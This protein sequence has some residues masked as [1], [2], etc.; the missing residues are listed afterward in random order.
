MSLFA[1]SL[2][3]FPQLRSLLTE[4]KHEIND[5]GGKEK[6]S[7]KRVENFVSQQNISAM[8]VREMAYDLLIKQKYIQALTLFRAS[9]RIHEIQCV[10]S[11]DKVR[12]IRNCVFDL[13]CVTEPLITIG[14]RSRDFG[15][16]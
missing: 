13:K 15:L 11:D 16:E 4:V 7:M 10:P 12:W 2:I 6:D 5:G 3:N 1:D 14:G 8:K 9:Y